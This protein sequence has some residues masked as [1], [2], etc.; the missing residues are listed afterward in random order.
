MVAR[1]RRVSVLSWVVRARHGVGAV[2]SKAE[3]V[4]DMQCAC[5]LHCGRMWHLLGVEQDSLILLV[6]A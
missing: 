1:V 3:C 6:T 5:E 4:E 2:R